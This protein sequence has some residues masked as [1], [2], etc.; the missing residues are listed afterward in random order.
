M[1]CIIALPRR[2]KEMFRILGKI[3]NIGKTGKI[4]QIMTDIELANHMAANDMRYIKF[5]KSMLPQSIEEKPDRIIVND[6][7]FVR[8]IVV[9]VP[10]G[11]KPGYPANISSDFLDDIMALSSKNCVISYSFAVIPISTHESIKM[12]EQAIYSLNVSLSQTAEKDKNLKDISSEL[13]RQDFQKIG[14]MLHYGKGKQFST[15][16]IITIW[17]KDDESLRATESRVILILKKHVVEFDI[18]KFKMMEAYRA[19][20]P[21][22][23]S[24]EDFQVE[25]FS[26]YAAQLAALQNPNSR[27]SEYGYLVGVDRHTGKQILVDPTIT[28]HATYTGATGGGKTTAMLAHLRRAYSLLGLRAIY[29]TPKADSQTD[30]R[31]VA[32][33]I[34]DNAA[35]LDIGRYGKYN[36]NP[37]QILYGSNPDRYTFSDHIELLL[38]FFNTL[39]AAHKKETGS[40]NMDNEINA[41]LK[42]L[43][44]QRGIIREDPQTWINAAWPTLSDLH[45]YWEKLLKDDPKNV[46]LQALVNKTA[47]VDDQ[48]DFLNK[49]TNIDMSKD[50]LVFDLSGCPPS[51]Q[52]ALNVFVTGLLGQLFS[53]SD[54]GTI[55]CIDEASVFLEDELLAEFILK[56][57]R[58]GRSA[59]LTGWFGTQSVMD[60]TLN[61]KAAAQFQ[62]NIFQ[63]YIFGYN[64]RKENLTVVQNYFKLSENETNHLIGCHRGEG[65]AKIG[66]ECIPLKV[67]LSEYEFDVIKGKKAG[68]KVLSKAQSVSTFPSTFQLVD[69]SL[70][71]L[72]EKHGIVIEDWFKDKNLNLLNLGYVAKNVQH[73]IKQGRYNAWF[74]KDLIQN[75]KISPESPDHYAGVLEM[76]G[77]LLQHGYPVEI[78]HNDSVDLSTI[79]DERRIAF[80]YEIS[81][82]DRTTLIQKYQ[83]ALKDHSEVFFIGTSS[84]IDE[85]SEVLGASNV[86]PRGEQFQE[87]VTNL[88]KSRKV[89]YQV[90]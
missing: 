81:K 35:I 89:L 68:R 62:A 11:T 25:L 75:N 16:L 5:L 60:F 41:T 37:L 29:I 56:I 63:S 9:G 40:I 32:I 54:K 14:E 48:W 78:N 27:T 34:G 10:R 80:E 39:F 52:T 7:R 6:N 36:I 58:M 74:R 87:F 4:R 3:R 66:M 82:K 43:Y 64:M 49:A 67:E 44:R 15:T 53:K 59:G 22:P 23:T 21:L 31:N 38:Q 57:L 13:D 70:H 84:N 8:C 45:K 72:I 77:L 55:L 12:A 1:H 20:L 88:L 79:I 69:E 86:I 28:L 61:P 76:A 26:D 18:P 73:V 50:F 24:S 90:L 42:E 65:I 2:C 33:A 19:S 46:T 30:Y 85:L 71:E 51:I 47:M 17:A 83:N